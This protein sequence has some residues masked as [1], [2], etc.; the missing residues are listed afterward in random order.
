MYSSVNPYYEDPSGVKRDVEF[1]TD[2]TGGNVLFENSGGKLNNVSE[3][4][5]VDYPGNSRSA[6]FLDLD[7]DGDLDIILNNLQEKAV[8][9]R[10]TAEKLNRNWLAVRLIGD[11]ARQTTRD[12]LGAKIIVETDTGIRVWREVHSTSGYLSAHPKEQH[13][14]LGTGKRARISVFWPNGERDLFTNA[15]VNRRYLITQGDKQLTPAT[16]PKPILAK[17]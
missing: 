10:N 11:P 7:G 17:Q 15:A 6:V 12:A 2:K 13:F 3:N 5:G 1:P 14:G 8:V 16:P 4:S 9:Y